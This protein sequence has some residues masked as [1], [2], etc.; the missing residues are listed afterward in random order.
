MCC[1]TRNEAY[2]KGEWNSRD[3]EEGTARLEQEGR[4]LC[5]FIKEKERE[6]RV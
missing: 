6:K 1:N 5:R 3:E 4:E 2:S